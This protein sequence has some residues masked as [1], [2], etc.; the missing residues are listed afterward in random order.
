MSD[1]TNFRFVLFLFNDLFYFSKIYFEGSRQSSCIVLPVENVSSILNSSETNSRRDAMWAQS[2]DSNN[3][4]IWSDSL[5]VCTGRSVFIIFAAGNPVSIAFGQYIE[6]LTRS[7][8]TSDGTSI[9]N[10]KLRWNER[11]IG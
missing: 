3:N 5:T 10:Y 4:F 8:H 1:Y 2:L 7:V 6:K 11:F 9:A